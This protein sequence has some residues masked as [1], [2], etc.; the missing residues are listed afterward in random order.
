[1]K[2]WLLILLILVMTMAGC[3]P[4]SPTVPK[5]KEGDIVTIKVSQDVGQVLYSYLSG[6]KWWYNV[7]CGS[8]ERNNLIEF[9]LEAHDEEGS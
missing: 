9:E 6:G 7:R 1:M 3:A 2:K 4:H 5:F 8:Y